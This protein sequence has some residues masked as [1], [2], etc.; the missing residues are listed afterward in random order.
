VVAPDLPL[1]NP[2]TTYAERIEPA[3]AALADVEGPIVVVGHSLG[4]GYAPLVAD[5]F[6]NAVLVYLCPAPVG[7]FAQ[8]EA[9]MPGYR[10]GFPFPR[11][12]PDGNSAWEREPAIAAMYRRLPSDVAGALADRLKPGSAPSDAYPQ[13]GHPA[14]PTTFVYAAHDEFFEPDW[15]R[16]AAREIAGVEPLEIETGHFAMAEAPDLVVELLLDVV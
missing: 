12:G 11:N 3:F 14:R 13:Q 2:Q 4:A 15:S 5:A 8:R 7:P 1:D 9:P 10:P 6:E 16:W